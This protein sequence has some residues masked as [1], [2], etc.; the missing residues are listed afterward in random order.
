MFFALSYCIWILILIYEA[1]WLLNIMCNLCFIYCDLC[2]WMSWIFLYCFS[3]L[4]WWC[5]KRISIL[6][7]GMWYILYIFQGEFN[8]YNP[9]PLFFFVCSS[10]WKMHCHHIG[11]RGRMWSY[12]RFKYN[13]YNNLFMYLVLMMTIIYGVVFIWCG[14]QV[15][16]L[17][18]QD[19]KIYLYRTSSFGGISN[20]KN[21]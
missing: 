14:D 4:F 17:G 19:I 11:R 1:F 7:G 3:L 5:L 6:L 10:P 20:I 15:V 13:D 8:H 2:A 9:L 16:V 21:N 12:A 18:D